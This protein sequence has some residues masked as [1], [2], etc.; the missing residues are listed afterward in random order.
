MRHLLTGMVIAAAVTLTPTLALAGN[1][2]MAEKI[3]AKLR[4]SGQIESYN[5]GVKYQ[6]GTVWLKGQVASQDEVSRA[7]RLAYQ[8]SGVE[9]VVNELSLAPDGETAD[10]ACSVRFGKTESARSMA[11]SS[12]SSSKAVRQTVAEEGQAPLPMKVSYL[13][14][15]AGAPAAAPEAPVAPA[16]RPAAPLPAAAAGG[17]PLPA[18][19]TPMGNQA[20][21]PMSYDQPQLPNYAWPSYAAYPNYAAVTYPRQYSA[22]AWPY[23]G[24][25]YPYPQVPLGWRKVTLQW[26]NGWWFLDFKDSACRSWSR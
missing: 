21:A 3:A 23:I 18:Y 11:K 24:P 26:D 1:Q 8:V 19:V 25:F 15:Q 17:R 13:Q 22:T 12:D 10:A 6:N 20:P 9:R 5:I 14:A 16:S 2:Q 4:D 7:M